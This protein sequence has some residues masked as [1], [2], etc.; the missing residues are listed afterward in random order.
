MDQ[1]RLIQ[2]SISI[3]KIHLRIDDISLIIMK[4]NNYSKILNHENLVF[5][6][7]IEK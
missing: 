7:F 6:N 1:R 5:K 3:N 2:V 4:K